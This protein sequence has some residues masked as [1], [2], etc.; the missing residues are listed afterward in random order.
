MPT[1]LRRTEYRDGRFDVRVLDDRT[2]RVGDRAG[3]AL[4]VTL[5]ADVGDEFTYWLPGVRVDGR[6]VAVPPVRFVYRRLDS[7]VQPFNC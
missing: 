5:P 6:D 2:I 3:F 7:G 1:E 4:E